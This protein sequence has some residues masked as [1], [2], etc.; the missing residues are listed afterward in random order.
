MT[1]PEL[2]LDLM[3]AFRR[4]KTLFAA[5]SL[6]VFDALENS[7]LDCQALSKKISAKTEALERLLNACT[8]LGLLDRRGGVYSNTLLSAE[9]LCESSP[10]SLASTIR[11]YN[12]LDYKK[13]SDL[14]TTIREESRE[15][16]Q[17]RMH[18]S[19]LFGS[20]GVIEACD[21]SQVQLMV[22]IGGGAGHFAI[23]AC[24]RYPQM[25]AIVLDRDLAEEGVLDLA[26]ANLARSSVAADRIEFVNGDFFTD[27]LPAGAD[28]F[29]LCRIIHHFDDEKVM[30]LLSRIHQALPPGG[31]VLIV[32]W[33]LADNKSGPMTALT[34]SL[35]M[36][37]VGAEGGVRS[38][39]E[40][41]ALLQ[42]AGFD[43]VKCF[44][45]TSG[46]L[47]ALLAVVKTDEARANHE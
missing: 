35:N 2:L 29:T 28:L 30:A 42:Q 1:D 41:T 19:A 7:P 36:L 31:S 21:L 46:Q 10:Y 13:W 17:R 4:S 27:D 24:E 32:E 23:E 34:Q 3:Q 26:I 15:K 20:R 22:D 11:R 44:R 8:G 25:R 45:A 14:E 18:G 38:V 43:Q 9:Y 5:V 40:Y 47:D 6:G 12:E 16:F 39:S 33:L 37:V